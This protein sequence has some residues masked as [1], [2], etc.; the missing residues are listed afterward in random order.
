[1][2]TILFPLI[3][4]I[5]SNSIS[6][7]QEKTYEKFSR[8]TQSGILYG[9]KNKKTQKEIIPA[10]YKQI[11]NFD[12]YFAVEKNN[13]LGV[14]DTLNQVKLPFKYVSL[15][16]LDENKM[17]RFVVSEGKFNYITNENGEQLGNST[18]DSFIN[19][20][21]GIVQFSKNNK[22]GYCDIDGKL[23]L[24]PK[25]DS[26]DTSKNGFIVTYT[27]KWNSL[28]YDL[29]TYNI[30]GQEIQRQD[31]GMTGKYPLLFNENGKLLFKGE[32]Y[33]DIKLLEN[34]QL[35]IASKQIPQTG[36]TRYIFIDIEGKTKAYFDEYYGLIFY[37]DYI[38]I[39]KSYNGYVGIMDYDGKII[40]PPNFKE[41]SSFVHDSNKLAKVFFTDGEYFYID[42]GLKCVPFDN[43]NCPDLE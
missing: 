37:D 43:K 2:K 17:D 34:K 13:F 29:V 41:I 11:T 4:F 8:H 3:L 5:L 33:E 15:Y 24:E 19:Y 42:K 26:G 21:D 36:N 7:G 16:F 1:M 10:I 32:S 31:I 23:I 20:N 18:F 14:I 12:K 35:A 9:I 25:F 22:I 38:K 6:F 28:G 39:V 27:N 40:F 30:F